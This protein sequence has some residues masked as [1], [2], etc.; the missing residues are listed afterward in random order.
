[1]Y[2]TPFMTARRLPPPRL[3]GGTKPL[4]VRPFVIGQV[5]RI[6]QVI[7]AILRP[8]LVRPQCKP[9]P[10]Q[11]GH[12]RIQVTQRN[13]EVLGRTLRNRSAGVPP[14][15]GPTPDAARPSH[16]LPSSG[17]LEHDWTARYPAIASA[18]AKIRAQSFTLDG[19]AVVCGEDGGAIFDALH[20]HGTVPAAILQAFDLLD[21]TGCGN[22]MPAAPILVIHSAVG[23]DLP[24]ALQE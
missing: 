19:E 22:F 13:Q 20:R 1:M 18:A 4:D 9:L 6:S 11:D 15:Q 16:L 7:A 12:H 23:Q 8:V 3:A 24:L 10:N 2:I 5:A 21:S 17:V 14:T